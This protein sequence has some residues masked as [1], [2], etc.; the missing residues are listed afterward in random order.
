MT[1]YTLTIGATVKIDAAVNNYG[2]QSGVVEYIDGE[3]DPIYGVRLD[4]SN[5]ITQFSRTEIANPITY[6]VLDTNGDLIAT[7]L[8]VAAAAAAKV[9]TDDGREFD[10]RAAEDGNGFELW[11]RQ[12][13]ANKGWTKTVVYSVEDD[14]SAAEAEIYAKVIAANWPRHPTVLTDQQYAEMLAELEA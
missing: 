8:P 13:V 6:T 14:I 5:W 3:A 10:I 1:T 7:G 11:T 9:L 12:Q 4:G 2:G